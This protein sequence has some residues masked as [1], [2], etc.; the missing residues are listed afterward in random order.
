M[1]KEKMRLGEFLVANNIITER[2]LDRALEEQGKF[3]GKLGETLVYLNIITE[4][5]LMAALRY[6]LGLPVVELSKNAVPPEVIRLVPKVIATRHR[7]VPIAVREEF[8]KRILSV[9]MANPMDIAAI[10]E[11][12]FITG[13]RITPVLARDR[14]IREALGKYYNYFPDG[15]GVRRAREADPWGREPATEG[16]REF[17]VRGDEGEAPARPR[18]GAESQPSV[19]G[20]KKEELF[21]PTLREIMDA[22]SVEAFAYDKRTGDFVKTADPFEEEKSRFRALVR[23]LIKKK[24]ITQQELDEMMKGL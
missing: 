6:H 4:D 11:L 20:E 9:A 12:A 10:E 7:V 8:G 23:L 16:R 17:R 15:R 14:E 21:G 22:P 13:F 24:I 2:E 19:R 5:K 1:A 3:K 18:P